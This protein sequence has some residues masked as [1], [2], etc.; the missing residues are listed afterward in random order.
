MDFVYQC[1]QLVHDSVLN[2]TELCNCSFLYCLSEMPHLSCGTCTSVMWWDFYWSGGVIFSR[3]MSFTIRTVQF[4]SQLV[5]CKCD[6]LI[7]YVSFQHTVTLEK[8][9]AEK[10]RTKGLNMKLHARRASDELYAHFFFIWKMF[11]PYRKSRKIKNII[12]VLIIPPPVGEA[13]FSVVRLHTYVR[14]CVC[15][16]MCVYNNFAALFKQ[17]CLICCHGDM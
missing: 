1:T 16:C 17:S 14:L 10:S 7:N 12:K 2:K 13:G 8:L 11:T 9:I 4:L 15:V 5:M 6:W 3:I